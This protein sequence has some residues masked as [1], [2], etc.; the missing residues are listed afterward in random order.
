SKSLPHQS[1]KDITHDEASEIYVNNY[2]APL[3][4]DAKPHPLDLIMFDTGVNMGNGV[5]VR[6]LQQAIGVTADGSFGPKSQAAL[7]AKKDAI[8]SVA[9]DY[10]AARD[11]R[12]HGLVEKNPKLAKFLKGWLNRLNDLKATAG[13]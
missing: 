1:V 3:K 6:L 13:L 9:T 11:K 10:I 12:Y 5:A 2:W 8:K 7:D 4:C